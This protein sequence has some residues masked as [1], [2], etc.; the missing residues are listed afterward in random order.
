MEVESIHS[1]SMRFGTGLLL[2]IWFSRGLSTFYI[3]KIIMSNLRYW[4]TKYS[5][6]TLFRFMWI[7]GVCVPI[8]I[9]SQVKRGIPRT[10]TFKTILLRSMKLIGLGLLYNS[11]YGPVK[12][13]EHANLRI[14]GVLQRFG[15]C[16]F[17][18][19]TLV[20]WSMTVN[21]TKP[22]G[23]AVSKV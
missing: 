19:S 5:P 22:G 17:V 14:P 20:L 23:R 3:M 10:K 2:Q 16:Y 9:K 1:L 15:V 7:M 21:F 18:C 13:G 8:S 6:Q 12:F 11:I 4:N